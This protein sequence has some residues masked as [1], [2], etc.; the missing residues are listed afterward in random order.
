MKRHLH[1]CTTSFSSLFSLFSFLFMHTHTSK[2]R[3]QTLAAII[4]IAYFSNWRKLRITTENTQPTKYNIYLDRLDVTCC[5]KIGANI[6]RTTHTCMHVFI[7]YIYTGAK[8]LKKDMC[9]CVCVGCSDVVLVLVLVLSQ[10]V[11]VNT[12]IIMHNEP[13]LYF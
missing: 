11:S 8:E 1:M 9:V 4:T 10:F 3:A 2:Y 13:I 7:A 6:S 5:W 12:K